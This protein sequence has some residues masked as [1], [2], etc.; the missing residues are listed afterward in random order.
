MA[1]QEESSRWRFRAPQSSDSEPEQ[2]EQFQTADE[3]SPPA[4]QTHT[5]TSVFTPSHRCITGTGTRPGIAYPFSRQMTPA[6]SPAITRTPSTN[7]PQQF[8]STSIFDP[9]DLSG[10]GILPTDGAHRVTDEFNTLVANMFNPVSPIEHEN[11]MLPEQVITDNMVEPPSNTDIHMSTTNIT[12]SNGKGAD[13]CK[14]PKDFDGDKAK[15]KTWLRMVEAYLQAN[16]NMF[17]DNTKRI[18]YILSTINIGNATRWA[19]HFLDMHTSTSNPTIKVYNGK[20]KLQGGSQCTRS[21]DRLCDQPT[22]LKPETQMQ[23]TSID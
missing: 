5:P 20:T 9:I 11:P 8:P 3:E 4:S 7:T 6:R 17:P 10:L 12:S 21:L 16:K 14:P 18:N 13:K 19:E 22:L 1:A 23:W 2:T 15:F